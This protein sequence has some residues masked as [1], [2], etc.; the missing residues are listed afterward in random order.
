MEKFYVIFVWEDVDPTLYGPFPSKE[1][2][3]GYAK[4]LRKKEGRDH[5]IYPLNVDDEGN[6]NIG[7]YT[8]IFF[9]EE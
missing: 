1:K 7:S 5:G 9:G 8:G 6:L 2:R 3:D 4:A